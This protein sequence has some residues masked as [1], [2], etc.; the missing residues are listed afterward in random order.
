MEVVTV[1]HECHGVD[2]REI[3]VITPYSAQKSLIREL[4]AEKQAK[5]TG[6]ATSSACRDPADTKLEELAIVSI[7]ESQGE[8]FLHSREL[9]SSVWRYK[10]YVFPHPLLQVMNMDM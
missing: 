4:K 10:A 9:Q 6:S 8:V 2:Y 7:T 5:A 3:A 1:L